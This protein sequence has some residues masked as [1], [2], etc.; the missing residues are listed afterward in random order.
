M[1]IEVHPKMVSELHN[2]QAAFFTANNVY[3]AS[4][5]LVIFVGITMDHICF[6]DNEIHFLESYKTIMGFN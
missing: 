3:K 2:K 4:Q 5:L 1:Y 6:Q